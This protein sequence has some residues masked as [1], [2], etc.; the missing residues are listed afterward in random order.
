MIYIYNLTNNMSQ[1]QKKC[2]FKDISLI[3][4]TEKLRQP[5]CSQSKKKRNEKE[6]INHATSV[7]KFK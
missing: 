3:S 2:A 7:S 6:N 4:V 5:S 1:S